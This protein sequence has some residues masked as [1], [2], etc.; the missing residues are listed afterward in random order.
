[1]EKLI[2]DMSLRRIQSKRSINLATMLP[3]NLALWDPQ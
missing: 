2:L 1:V 3:I